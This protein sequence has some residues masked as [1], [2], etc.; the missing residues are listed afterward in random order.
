MDRFLIALTLASVA[1]SAA[2]CGPQR[3]EAPAWKA[4]TLSEGGAAVLR[5]AVGEADPDSP[6]L[7]V[8]A[9]DRA[10]AVFMISEPGSAPQKLQLHAQGAPVQCLLV[11]DV[12]PGARGDEVYAAGFDE[13]GKAGAAVQI[14][15]REGATSVKRI[16]V[17]NSPATSLALLPP[18]KDA[19]TPELALATEAGDVVVL[20]PVGGDGKWFAKTVHKADGRINRMVS[21]RIGPG[22]GRTLFLATA[23][24][25]GVLLDVDS[26][27]G[28]AVIHEEKVG[29]DSAIVERGGTLAAACANGRLLRIALKGKEWGWVE[30]FRDDAA[31]RSVCAGDFA[32]D[33]GRSVFA[34]F[35]ASK[36]VLALEPAPGMWK[37]TTLSADTGEGRSIAAADL[38]RGNGSDEIVLGGES[39]R[40]VL[41]VRE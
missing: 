18:E 15:R 17:G 10:G 40:V 38:A 5:V 27:A 29:I 11:A 23:S 9:A 36:N 31:L 1:A 24:G 14:L 30:I 13:D 20:H 16:W 33:S 19:R 41:L 28:A 21:G 22:E 7:E 8:V 32:T 37:S 26:A 34:T 25:K 2:G 6:G 12:D 4:R 3:R 39:G 35:G